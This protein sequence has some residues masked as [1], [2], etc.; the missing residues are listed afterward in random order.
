M[1]LA[2]NTDDDASDWLQELIAYNREAMYGN[3]IHLI[4]NTCLY[5]TLYKKKHCSMGRLPHLAK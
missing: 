4:L 3:H 1:D 2:N 5:S